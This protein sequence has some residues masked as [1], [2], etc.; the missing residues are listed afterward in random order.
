M[1]EFRCDVFSLEQLRGLVVAPLP[2]GIR[3]GATVRSLFRDL[4]LD[5]EDDALRRRGVI[6]RLRLGTDDR[7]I[8]SLRIAPDSRAT[9]AAPEHFDAHVRAADPREAVSE[10][11]SPGRRVRALVDPAR[12]QVRVDLEVERH[13]RAALTDWFGRP[14]LALHYDHVT[15][16]RGPS[17]RT[18]QQLRVRR[19][20]GKNNIEKLAAA[21]QR[22]HGLR[23][24][25]AGP[26]E[27]AEL[28]LKWMTS[29]ATPERKRE[30]RRSTD[31][32]QLAPAT[33]NEFLDSELSLLAFQQRVL[34]LAED[35]ST[36]LRERLRFL[37]IVSANID[38]FFTV[39][40]AGLKLAG[41]EQVE[42]HGAT[43]A[44]HA[45]LPVVAEAVASL[46]ARQYRALRE[47]LAELSERGTRIRM[48][49][50][51]DQSDRNEL[52]QR[53]RDEV[54]PALTPLAMTLSP[55]HPFPRLTH[56]ALSVAVVL[57]DAQGGTP[58]FADVEL[59]ADAPRFMPIGHTG[60]VVPLEEVLRAN[61]DLLYPEARADQAYCFRVTR[62]GELDLAEDAAD[63]LLEAVADATKR[64]PNNA[65]VRL[66]V[67]RDM[68][69]ILRELLI[70]ELRSEREIGGGEGGSLKLLSPRDIYEIDG[71]LDLRGLEQFP[72]SKDPAVRYPPF[73]GRAPVPQARPMFDVVRERDLLLH[74]PFDDFDASVGRF[75]REAA[76]DPNVSAIKA[77]L[78][79]VGD[80]S[81][82]V[83]ALLHAA[84]RG[85][86]VV[87]FVELKARF[88]EERN[89]AWA[90]A[91]EEA[92][93]RV[94]YGLVGLKNHAKVSLV[95]RRETA[96]ADGHA[97]LHRY[98]HV[99]TGNYN[100]RTARQYTDLSLL[101]A[102]ESLTSDVSDLFN[103]FTGSSRPPRP[104]RTGALVA[105][106]QL[107]PSILQ[108]IEREASH[109]RAGRPARIRLKLNGLSDPEVVRALYRASQ[110]GVEID[111]VVR[112]ICT[113]RP[114][115]AERSDRIRVVSVTGR[116]LEHSR[117]YSFA[118]GGEPHYYIGSADLR[119]RNLRRRVELLV[120][121]RGA[122][123]R[124]LLD[125]ILDVYL[126]D[127][128]AWELLET[129]DYV[130]RCGEDPANDRGAQSEL[131]RGALS[132]AR[133]T[134][135]EYSPS[136]AA[137][138]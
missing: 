79:R 49:A 64:R 66:E 60:D 95:V 15:V 132:A 78:Y 57:P 3:S 92:G 44:P 2:L 91:L 47:C 63:D 9:S 136:R 83:D 46:V 69:E 93:G 77:T 137:D 8:L 127:P 1:E 11:T 29:D 105:P 38:E 129:G 41:R 115:V 130:R 13:A 97:K 31:I 123:D 45:Q 22:V 19:L 82:L 33:S 52:R 117:I 12:L 94:V 73:V 104:L 37:A 48:W 30:V 42:E 62:T 124:E 85:K 61:L 34:A 138:R 87:A 14:R 5:T 122:R 135:P 24:I 81:P 6:C 113:L 125:R 54:Y 74:H 25:S 56:L 39:R 89:V 86:E 55:G 70:Q 112:G 84:K 109:A 17:T 28:L 76:A 114:G 7:R 72:P 108:H 100:A 36:P 101:S 98:V 59:P 35:P 43:H 121:I 21:F 110:D 134:G 88:D 40:V 16:R 26:R 103:D 133:D 80:D 120:P 131:L 51:L 90:R 128:T 119:P 116:F 10:D 99:G 67:E 50:E 20:R 107:L 53:L 71:L 102:N 32:S 23:L 4:Y 118:N 58:H 65:V 75:F 111:L 96:D 126:C 68:P 27:R 106:A 18:F